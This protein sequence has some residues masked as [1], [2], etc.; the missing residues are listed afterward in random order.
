MREAGLLGIS[1]AKGPRTTV[2]GSGADTHP[3]LVDRASRA[4]APALARQ[5]RLLPHLLG[6]GLA[7][8]HHDRLHSDIPFA[9]QCGASSVRAR[10]GRR[11]RQRAER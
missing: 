6:L 9:A 4:A 8:G 7:G 5:H 11:Q 2:P 10:S 3:D 1:R